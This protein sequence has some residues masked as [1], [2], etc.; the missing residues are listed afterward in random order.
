MSKRDPIFLIGDILEATGKIKAYTKKYKIK[1][2]IIL[3]LNTTLLLKNTYGQNNSVITFNNPSSRQVGVYQIFYH[4]DSTMSSGY[5]LLCQN[6]NWSMS[7]W[8]L[9]K[10]IR[11]DII[12]VD[13]KQLDTTYSKSYDLS[14]LQK[15]PITIDVQSRS[16]EALPPFQQK[17]RLVVK[18]E[19]LWLYFK[20]ASAIKI[21]TINKGKI[22][23]KISSF[24][25]KSIT[26]LTD[27]NAFM[28]FEKFE[29]KGIKHCGYMFAAGA[30]FHIIYKCKY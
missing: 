15:G 17:N 3:L 20:I 2:L 1:I 22:E 10:I 26:I 9:S 11:L 5:V 8:E 18:S 7:E 25:R 16:R 13:A 27:K 4:A 29:I 23:G 21:K 19:K 30:T 28:T 24:D 6:C 14:T 12:G